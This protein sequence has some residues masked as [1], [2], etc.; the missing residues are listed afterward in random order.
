LVVKEG[1]GGARQKSYSKINRY[2][3][4]DIGQSTSSKRI[5]KSNKQTNEEEEE[6]K[7]EEE[8]RVLRKEE[9]EKR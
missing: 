1:E 6:E 3:G 7:K 9:K 5:S 2:R 4:V 8:R